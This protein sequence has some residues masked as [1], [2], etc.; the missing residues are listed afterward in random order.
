MKATRIAVRLSEDA[1]QQL[2]AAAQRLDQSVS[3]FI[4][5][6]ALERAQNVLATPPLA[7]SSEEAQRFLAV[8]ES[9]PKPNKALRRLIEDERE[10]FEAGK[11]AV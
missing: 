9:P 4:L 8:L 5:G 3:A 11:A 6:A 10:Y 2:E 1:K 7:L